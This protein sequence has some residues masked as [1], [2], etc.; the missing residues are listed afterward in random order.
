MH[1]LPWEGVTFYPFMQ[2]SHFFV[3]KSFGST[4]SILDGSIMVFIELLSWQ[5]FA[6]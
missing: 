4:I 5:W 2:Q 6:V 1:Y 3:E